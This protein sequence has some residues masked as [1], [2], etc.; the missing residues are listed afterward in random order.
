MDPTLSDPAAADLLDSDRHD[1][2]GFRPVP[3]TPCGIIGCLQRRYTLA[4]YQLVRIISREGY[5]VQVDEVGGLCL[6]HYED[7]AVAV[8]TPARPVQGPYPWAPC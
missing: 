8:A 6:A 7:T 5:P 2:L 3:Q 1:L 4:F